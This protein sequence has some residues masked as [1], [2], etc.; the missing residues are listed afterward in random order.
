MKASFALIALIG[1]AA[2]GPHHGGVRTGGKLGGDPKF[3]E[4]CSKYNKNVS[5]TASFTLR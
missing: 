5:T 1:V 3:L 2:A 4:Y